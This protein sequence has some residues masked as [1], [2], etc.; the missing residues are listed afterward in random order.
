MHWQVGF[1]DSPGL[2][3]NDSDVWVSQTFEMKK[4]YVLK[5]GI[6]KRNWDLS[7]TFCCLEKQVSVC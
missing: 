5:V 1:S 4:K 7:L 3:K 6:Y 2:Q